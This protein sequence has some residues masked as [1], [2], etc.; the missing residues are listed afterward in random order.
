M[1]FQ[2]L[3]RTNAQ[4]L[5]VA[6]LL[7]DEVG[8]FIP[9]ACIDTVIQLTGFTNKDHIKALVHKFDVEIEFS[10]DVFDVMFDAFSGNPMKTLQA[11]YRI[12]D[13]YLH[14]L[15]KQKISR[16]DALIICNE[17]LTNYKKRA[18]MVKNLQ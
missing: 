8:S 6:G 14:N 11:C 16:D 5:F 18:E 10:N 1:Q 2:L 17:I 4:F 9:P 3:F 7:F 12:Y 13:L 15:F